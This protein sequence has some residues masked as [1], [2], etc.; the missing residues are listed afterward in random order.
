MKACADNNGATAAAVHEWPPIVV[1][2]LVAELS[3]DAPG[4]HLFD[5]DVVPNAIG[6]P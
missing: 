2:F 3:Q 1:H 5:K 4:Q 6:S